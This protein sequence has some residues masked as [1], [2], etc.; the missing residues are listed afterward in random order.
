MKVF[1]T[2]KDDWGI[3][4]GER[5]ATVSGEEDDVNSAIKQILSKVQVI[6][7]LL[8]QFKTVLKS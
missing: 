1:L 2:S 6:I 5:V 8:L 7:L 3:V 4:P